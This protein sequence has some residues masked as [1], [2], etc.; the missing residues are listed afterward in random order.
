MTERKVYIDYNATTP[1]RDEVKTVLTE[2]FDNYGNASSLH[3]SGRN[4]RV[5]YIRRGKHL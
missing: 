2:N 1:M 4:A 3:E 5:T